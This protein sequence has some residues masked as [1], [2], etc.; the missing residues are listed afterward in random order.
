MRGNSGELRCDP[1]QGLTP[2]LILCPASTHPSHRPNKVENSAIMGSLGVE[3]IEF[4]IRQTWV[5]IPDLPFVGCVTLGK[6]LDISVSQFPCLQ[7]GD[8]SSHYLIGLL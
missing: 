8:R 2:K 5:Q 3:L 6:S 4:G 7:N 1:T